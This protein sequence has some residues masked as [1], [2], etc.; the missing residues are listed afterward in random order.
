[1]SKHKVLKE[2]L[3]GERNYNLFKNELIEIERYLISKDKLNKLKI[4]NF[5]ILMTDFDTRVDVLALK[6]LK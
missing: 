2:W 3:F 4:C 5:D 6:L 1:M